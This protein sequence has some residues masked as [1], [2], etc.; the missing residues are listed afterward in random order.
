MGRYD[1][2]SRCGIEDK[3]QVRVIHEGRVQCGLRA[4]ED[5]H[6]LRHDEAAERGEHLQ[7]HAVSCALH[8]AL[9]AAGDHAQC[10]R[11]DED[12]HAG[13]AALHAWP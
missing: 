6:P 7:F 12:V 9:G 13:T 5:G 11:Y 8:A 4:D 10:G 3:E 2:H 1:S